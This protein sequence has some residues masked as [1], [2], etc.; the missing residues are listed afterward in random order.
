MNSSHFR[1]RTRR[2]DR[3]SARLPGFLQPR[4]AHPGRA[5]HVDRRVVAQ[6]GHRRL[7]LC[8]GSA[9]SPNVF[10]DR[11]DC[12]IQLSRKG[13]KGLAIFERTSLERGACAHRRAYERF[14]RAVG[15]RIDPA[16][17]LRRLERTA[18]AGHERCDAVP[19]AR[20]VTSGANGV[21][22]RHRRS[23]RRDVRKDGVGHLPGFPR[24]RV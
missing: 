1:H 24:T 23:Q 19:P 15:R 10:T 16:L 9:S 14:A 11:I 21:R 22:R 7:H 17:F 8:Q 20:R 5:D 6:S 13:P 2:F 12:S 18:D 3:L 4:R